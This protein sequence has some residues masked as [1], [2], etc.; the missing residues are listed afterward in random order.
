MDYLDNRNVYY[1]SPEEIE[2]I[3]NKGYGS[4][5]LPN[6]KTEAFSIGMTILE[7]ATLIIS[8]DLYSMP[9]R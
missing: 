8:K 1:L 2:F 9:S 3:K 4:E 5:K 6:P 7:C